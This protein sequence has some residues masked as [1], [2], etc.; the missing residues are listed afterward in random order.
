MLPQGSR[1]PSDD[2]PK[3]IHAFPAGAWQALFRPAQL[4]NGVHTFLAEVPKDWHQQN[5][6]DEMER[7][8]SGPK[9]DADAYASHVL[10]PLLGIIIGA[11]VLRR[12][13]V[14]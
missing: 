11:L 12:L 14:N 10:L 1:I 3:E 7:L 4:K 6:R 5:Q 2:F 13:F 9:N 8:M